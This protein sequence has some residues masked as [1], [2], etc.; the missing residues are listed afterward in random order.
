MNYKVNDVAPSTGGHGFSITDSGGK[1]V[2][3]FEFAHEDKAKRRT[4]LSARPSLSR[5]RSR[6][7]HK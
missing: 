7:W 3:H 1:P 5:Q 4:G 2:V 6:Q